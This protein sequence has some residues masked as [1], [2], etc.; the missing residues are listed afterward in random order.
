MLVVTAGALVVR[1]EIRDPHAGLDAQVAGRL[2]AEDHGVG[3]GVHDQQGDLHGV[4]EVL[5]LGQLALGFALGLLGAPAVDLEPPEEEQ[6][7]EPEQPEAQLREPGPGPRKEHD[8]PGIRGHL[9]GSHGAL[10]LHH[11]LLDIPGSD[12]QPFSALPLGQRRH[13][14]DERALRRQNSLDV[15]PRTPPLLGERTQADHLGHHRRLDLAREGLPVDVE[16]DVRGQD[17]GHPGAGIGEGDHDRGHDPLSSEV[18][19]EP[20]VINLPGRGG[21]E[22]ELEEELVRHEVGELR[23][24]AELPP[25]IE[26][27]LP[28]GS[29]IGGQL[30]ERHGDQRA[31]L[32]EAIDAHDPWRGGGWA[33]ASRQPQQMRTDPFEEAVRSR[34]TRVERLATGH[35]EPVA[36]QLREALG[37]ELEARLALHRRDQA[38]NSR[39][40]LGRS[41]EQ[42]AEPGEIGRN[43]P[44]VLPSHDLLICPG[45]LGVALQRKVQPGGDA[46]SLGG[47]RRRLVLDELEER[48]GPLLAQP[49]LPLAID[50]MRGDPGE[51]DEEKDPDVQ[52]PGGASRIK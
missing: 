1:H 46:G 8:Q 34:V 37:T 6:E 25:L 51:E 19:V 35:H 15:C 9:E 5:L 38:R 48:L 28:S 49:A 50:R 18:Q 11:R 10:P 20:G 40:W 42:I 29:R 33:D 14:R 7:E 39:G 30:G 3:V 24:L 12:E 43:G 2:V 32:R 21:I 17:A 27:R 52:E 23:E 44:A 26:G 31:I 41:G 22:I 4:E 36:V 47:A 13:G 16:G 45:L